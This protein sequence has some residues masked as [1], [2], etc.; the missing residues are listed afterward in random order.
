[1]LLFNLLGSLMVILG[2]VVAALAVPDSRAK[3]ISITVSLLLGAAW[4]CLA[5]YVHEQTPGNVPYVSRALISIVSFVADV[6]QSRIFQT[7]IALIVGIILGSQF[8]GI[9]RTDAKARKEAPALDWKASDSVLELAAPSKIND[10]REQLSKIAELDAQLAEIAQL[11]E[12]DGSNISTKRIK[13]R[14]NLMRFKD[15]TRQVER[16]LYL[17]LIQDIYEGLRSGT[18][19]GRGFLLPVGKEDGVV[20]IPSNR[21]M[22]LRLN[23]DFTKASGE[24]LT[25]AGLQIARAT[26]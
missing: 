2:V 8:S 19:I 9:K 1:M 16:V 22:F 11:I 10:R 3:R 4:L 23:D 24:N 14:D 15:S 6:V 21:W 5:V 25:Y 7:A 13:K 18:L 26:S 17:S 20:N 12:L